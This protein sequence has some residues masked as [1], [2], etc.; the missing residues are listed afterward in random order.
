MENDWILDVIQDLRRFAD[1]NNMPLLADQLDGAAKAASR[2]LLA[3]GLDMPGGAGPDG[4][5][6]GRTV[7]RSF[8]GGPDA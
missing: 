5:E 7:S 2:E 1:L 6:R 4:R 3:R 8:A